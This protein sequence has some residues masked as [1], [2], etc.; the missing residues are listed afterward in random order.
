M[1]GELRDLL[2]DE[3]GWYRHNDEREAESYAYMM[4]RVPIDADLS[5]RATREDALDKALAAFIRRVTRPR[6]S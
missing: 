4:V 1:S 6:H 5:C 3:G 2:L